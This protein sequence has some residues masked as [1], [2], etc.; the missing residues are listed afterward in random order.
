MSLKRDDNSA[1]NQNAFTV[2][3]T[4]GESVY[5]FDQEKTTLEVLIKSEIALPVHCGGSGACGCCKIRIEDNTIIRHTPV[6]TNHLSDVQLKEGIRLACQVKPQHNLKIHL[7]H[8]P[9]EVEWNNLAQEDV[10]P[11]VYPARP[12]TPNKQHRFGLAIDIGTTQIRLSLWD[13]K[14]CQRINARSCL[15]PQVRFGSDILRRIIIAVESG[16][17]AKRMAQL[18]ARAL[19]GAI[20]DFKEFKDFSI[21]KIGPVVVVGN[22]AMLAIISSKNFEQLLLPQY[23]M[24]EV[25]CQPKNI[26]S[27]KDDWQLTRQASLNL[28]PAIAGFVGSDLLAGIISTRLHLD[29]ECA[30][31]ID[32]GTNSEIALWDGQ[33]LWVTSAAGGPAFDGCGISCGMP[34]GPGAVYKINGHTSPENFSHGVIG[35]GA[36][37][38][39]CGSGLVDAVAA[40]I[41]NGSLMPSGRFK[42]KVS[43]QAVAFVDGQPVIALKKRDIDVFQRAK[44]AIGAGVSCLLREANLPM[45]NLERVFVCG[46]FGQHLNIQNAKDIGLLPDISVERFKIFGNAALAGCEQ[47]MLSENWKEIVASIKHQIKMVDLA[48]NRFFE[49]SFPNHLFLQPTSLKSNFNW[50]GN[51]ESWGDENA[52]Q[53]H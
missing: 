13:I 1:E 39:I 4:E 27:L 32:F 29:H 33:R 7:I 11:V 36:P 34:A 43:S 21:E 44:A 47:L 37:K 41:K 25:D 28:V 49:T 3:D 53:I 26:N 35:Q 8:S 5:A 31:L 15:N 40:L 42:N 52:G 17:D 23:W 18:C 20:R 22:T 16:T 45:E 50:L 9:R 6:E 30:L 24:N 10:P 19:A 46:A 12:L 48:Q 51:A 38:G 14:L 2:I